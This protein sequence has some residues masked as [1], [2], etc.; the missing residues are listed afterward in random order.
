MRLLHTIAVL[1]SLL[2]CGL[3]LAQRASDDPTEFTNRVTAELAATNPEAARVF[4]EANTARDG[5]DWARAETLYREVL[6]MEPAFHHAKRRLCYCVLAQGRRDEALTLC[7]E[8]VEEGGL[9]EDRYALITA[10]LDPQWGG[11]PDAMERSE[12][13][14]H[15]R[16]LLGNKTADPSLIAGV[17]QTALAINELSML[18]SCVT[19]LE[20][21]V[22][23]QVYTQYYTWI[24]A[25]S[26]GDHARATRAL[27]AARELGLPEETY[28]EMKQETRKALPLWSRYGTPAIVVV[29]VW[30]AGL[31]ALLVAG[32]VLSRIALNAAN[33]PPDTRSGESAGLTAA[34][35]K[36]YR[37]VMWLS[38]VYYYV[39]IPIVLLVVVLAG[40]G[41]IY[42]FYAVGRI[43]VKLAVVVA[44]VVLV[45]VWAVLRSF[46]VRSRD[47]DPGD[48]LD[49]DEHPR[50]RGT[51]DQV[52]A[53][54]DTRPVDNVYMTPGT[55][56]AVME[57]GGVL[58]Q[59]RG[60]SERCLIL[61]VGVLDGM[62]L[63]PFKAILAHE[64]GHFSNRDT[65]GG[66]F[67]LAVRR[68]LLAMAQSLAEG[69]AAAW[70]NP[71]WLFL[72]GFHL[73]FLRISQ[74]ASRLQEVLA[75]RWAAFAYSAANFERGLRHVIERSIR[76]DVHASAT[77]NQ[78]VE[79]VKPL[80]NLYS[81]SPSDL[82]GEVEIVQAVEQALAAEPSPYDSH[83]APRDRFRL[84]H[85]LEASPDGDLSDAAEDAWSLFADREQI[86]RWMTDRVRQNVSA[87]HGIMIHASEPAA[88]P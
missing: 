84:V 28:A 30:L 57:R 59:I 49:V 17:C 47:E 24:L 68:S 10:L 3:A 9:P 20:R 11:E 61:G 71:A 25:M 80:S 15:A 1:F 86:E 16:S 32:F 52:A 35:G 12:A 66:G 58:R 8:S 34:V 53:Q 31:L 2:G 40:G 78:V 48:R 6:G 64:Y 4:T 21:R 67:A 83:P 87:T 38:C 62:K 14:M 33:R 82:P 70:Y 5:Q 46:F 51:L 73:V 43:P 88:G 22:P 60:S 44:I 7:R 39:S 45:T 56:L 13:A 55:D 26:L 65:A 79:E 37:T 74:G 81:F 72:N 19:E 36:T 69:G 23:G 41:I 42:G 18:Q 63:G 77:L 29:V 50:L 85:A 75:D 76:F 54:I 27:E